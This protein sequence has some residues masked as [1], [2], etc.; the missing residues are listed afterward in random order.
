[1]STREEIEKFFERQNLSLKVK[2]SNPRFLDQKCTP[3][4]LQIVAEVVVNIS[5][6]EFTRQ[7]IQ[8]S[9]HL[10]KLI[11]LGFAKAPPADD[12]ASNEYDKFVGQNLNLLSYAGVLTRDGNKTPHTFRIEERW[13]LDYIKE[14]E[15]N[16]YNF[17]V[18]YGNKFIRDNELSDAF[19]DF[20]AS[21]TQAS[22]QELK[23]KLIM[24]ML[25]NT[26]IGNKGSRGD[27]EIRRIY[28]KLLN[29]LACDKGKKGVVR[30]RFS[31]HVISMQDL[32]YDRPNFRDHDKPPNETRKEQ[33]THREQFRNED[34]RIQAAKRRVKDLH[35]A[36]EVRGEWAGKTGHIHH[37]FPKGEFPE[38]AMHPENLIA[39]TTGQH[40]QLAHPDANTSKIDLDYQKTCLLA[41]RDTIERC[42]ARKDNIYSKESFVHVINVGFGWEGTE[43]ALP[44]GSFDKILQAIEEYYSSS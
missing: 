22:F 12:K 21:Q 7:S 23:D 44:T 9:D 42:F 3:I 13:I 29:I 35:Q 8:S 16:A 5:G 39:L 34:V 10:N 17:L 15:R 6:E 19:G 30:G 1:M 37:I 4:T 41:K 43:K 25:A 32:N 24:F 20:F 40:L 18:F 38:I 11:K 14:S 27:V 2:G 28:P 26:N 31:K 33:E 36:S